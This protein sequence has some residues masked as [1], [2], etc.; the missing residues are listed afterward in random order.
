MFREQ[1]LERC[2]CTV[3]VTAHAPPD[4]LIIHGL[5]NSISDFRTFYFPEYVG[6]PFPLLLCSFSALVRKRIDL[7]SMLG[8]Y[9]VM[10][11][12]LIVSF[13]ALIAEIVWKKRQQRGI[14]GMVRRS[15][16]I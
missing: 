5:R 11:V 8:V 6:K 15:V 7:K 10:G 9:V 16:N 14:I 1:S 13:L 12:G 2:T 4:A 3:F